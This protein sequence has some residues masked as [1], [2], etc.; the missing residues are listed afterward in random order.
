MKA[1][2]CFNQWGDEEVVGVKIKWPVLNVLQTE[3]MHNW[4]MNWLEWINGRVLGCKV[5]WLN[6]W[7]GGWFCMVRWMFGMMIELKKKEFVKRISCWLVCRGNSFLD[8]WWDTLI[9]YLIIIG[10]LYQLVVKRQIA[11]RLDFYQKKMSTPTQKNTLKLNK[12][13]EKAYNLSLLLI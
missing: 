9:E 12:Y 8:G 5:S 11:L 4:E 1:I 7:S 10:P 6:K 2:I 3:K 13:F